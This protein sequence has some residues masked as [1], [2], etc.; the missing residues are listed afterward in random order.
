MQ[1]GNSSVCR[2][3]YDKNVLI[4]ETEHAMLAVGLSAKTVTATYAQ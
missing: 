2:N 1:C 3:K 4:V